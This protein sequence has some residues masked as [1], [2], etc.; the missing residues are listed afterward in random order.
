MRKGKRGAAI[1]RSRTCRKE[2][3]T[4]C[5]CTACCSAVAD[6]R[7]FRCLSRPIHCSKAALGSSDSA[8]HTCSD[9]VAVIV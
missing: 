2:R 6:S 7:R 3:R 5:G 4:S 8:L 9:Y 1:G